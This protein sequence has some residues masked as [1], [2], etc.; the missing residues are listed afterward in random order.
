MSIKP[1]DDRTKI[2]QILDSPYAS[3]GE[4]EITIDQESQIEPW[5][6]DYRSEPIMQMENKRVNVVIDQTGVVEIESNK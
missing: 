6:P 3:L 1:G 2:V 5:F 4:P